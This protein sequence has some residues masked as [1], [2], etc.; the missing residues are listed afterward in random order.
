MLV[1]VAIP[2][3]A[4]GAPRRRPPSTRDG[5]IMMAE[6]RSVMKVPGVAKSDLLAGEEVETEELPG[7]SPAAPA[8]APHPLPQDAPRVPGQ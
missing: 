3:S 6:T 8:Q 4:A 5:E 1:T 7:T 2:P